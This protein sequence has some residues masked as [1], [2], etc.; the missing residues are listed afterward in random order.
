MTFRRPGTELHFFSESEDVCI[1]FF[2]VT[3]RWI[4]SLPSKYKYLVCVAADISQKWIIFQ[5]FL[6]FCWMKIKMLKFVELL[7]ELT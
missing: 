5:L 1:S 2:K 7:N 3:C 6:I 4:H